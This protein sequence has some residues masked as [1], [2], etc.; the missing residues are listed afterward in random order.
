MYQKKLTRRAFLADALVTSLALY[1]SSVFAQDA[2]GPPLV[3]TPSGP[4]RG[5]RLGSTRVFRG[6]PFAQPPVGPLRFRPP[7]PVKPWT[8]E[9]DAT[10]FAAEAM[11][12]S[13]PSAS[14][15]EDCLYLNIWAPE[16]KGPFPVS[17][18]IHGGGFTGGRSY[19]SG[20]EGIPFADAGVICV[21]VAYRLGVFGFLDLEPLLGKD[22]AG[23]ADNA[24]RD[25]MAALEWVQGNIA[26]FGGDPARVTVGG[27]SAGAKLTDILMGIPSAKPLFHQ[28]ISESGGAERVSTSDAAA[29]VANGFAEEWQRHNRAMFCWQDASPIILIAA[30]QQFL[31][32]WPQHFPLRGEVDGLLLPRLPVQTIAA[33]STRGKR[34][35]IGTNRDESA[36]F[37]GPHPAHDPT[38]ADLGNMPLAQFSGIFAQ[39]ANVYPDMTDERRRIRAVTAEEYWVPSIRAADAHVQGGGTAWMYRLDFAETSG[40]LKGYAYHSLD[41][42][43]AWD[44]P[45]S[46]VTNAAA[47]AAL[48]TQ[49]HQ[50]WVAF[51]RGESPSAPGLPAWPE[52]RP[53]ERPTMILDVQSRVEQRPQEAELR[54]WDGSL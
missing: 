32:R 2:A 18:W 29:K 31:D 42:G 35:L 13:D 53:Q 33:G 9:R 26:A 1:G 25:L 20:S 39:Y 40:R 8:Q 38:A 47:E 4:L 34:L 51:I 52:Y 30:Q 44:Q 24:L 28:M 7:L 27:E 22:Y 11:Q 43:L 3:N 45:H 10:R 46:D 15:S 36:L 14:Q 23:S 48:A 17:V 41:V 50:A 21:T 12:S 19:G 5:A 37:I 49:V 16:G 6:V 54:L